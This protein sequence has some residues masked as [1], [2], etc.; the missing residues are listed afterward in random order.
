MPDQKLHD[1]IDK[2]LARLR[3]KILERVDTE[4]PKYEGLWLR[5]TEQQ[6]HEYMEEEFL[7]ML[8]YRFM[9][10]ERFGDARSNT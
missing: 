10:E 7:D 5:L 4:G 9:I 2:G 1:A 8:A 3:E 6:L